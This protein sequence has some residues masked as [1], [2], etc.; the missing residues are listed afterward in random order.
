[1]KKILF[2]GACTLLTTM[3]FSCSADE[4]DT[5]IKKEVKKEAARTYADG[6]GDLP[7]I[8]PPPPEDE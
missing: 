8:P 2:W 6:P 1:M 3:L 7:T 5:T 4:D